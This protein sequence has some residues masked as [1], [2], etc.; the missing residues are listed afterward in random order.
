MV[1][2]LTAR[3][4]RTCHRSLRT[5]GGMFDKGGGVEDEVLDAAAAPHTGDMA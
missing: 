3:Q 5:P 1:Y 2:P 4:G